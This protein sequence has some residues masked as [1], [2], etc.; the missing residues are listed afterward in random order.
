VESD[1]CDPGDEVGEDV[2]TPRTTDPMAATLE[3]APLEDSLRLRL[4]SQRGLVEE[5]RSPQE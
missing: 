2:I 1:A 4:H 5:L 3:P